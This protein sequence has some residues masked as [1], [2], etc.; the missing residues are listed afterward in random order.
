[1]RRRQRPAVPFH[2][3][4]AEQF[5]SERQFLDRRLVGQTAGPQTRPEL[6]QV[7]ENRGAAG[8]QLHVP[9]SYR[10]RWLLAMGSIAVRACGRVPASRLTLAHRVARLVTVHTTLDVL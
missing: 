1:M 10:Y 4:G 9:F 3:V 5:R 2:L 8:Q 6:R 7:A